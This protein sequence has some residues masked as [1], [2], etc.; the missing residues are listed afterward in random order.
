MAKDSKPKVKK[1]KLIK[2]KEIKST[3]EIKE[4][5]E[6]SLDEKLEEEFKHERNFSNFISSSR[7]NPSTSS[8]LTKVKNQNETP[9]ENEVASTPSPTEKRNEQETQINYNVVSPETRYLQ[10]R[11]QEEERE[12]RTGRPVGIRQV[13]GRENTPRGVINTNRIEQRFAMQT[14]LDE[15]NRNEENRGRAERYV[16]GIKNVEIERHDI[17]NP[18]KKYKRMM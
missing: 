4:I 5:K 11:R 15:L 14:E 13:L 8:T 18:S 9:L 10:E 17:E 7:A 1:S 12:I 3:L 6:E 2:I 16:T